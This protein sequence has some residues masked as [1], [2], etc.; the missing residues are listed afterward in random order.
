MK[1]ELGHQLVQVLGHGVVMVAQRRL[2]RFAESPAVVRDDPITRAEQGGCLLLPGTAT[3]WP[4]VDKHDRLTRSV[5][6][7]VEIDAPEFSLPTVR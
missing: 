2:A 5:V 3:Q 6:L 4:T 7:I 1:V